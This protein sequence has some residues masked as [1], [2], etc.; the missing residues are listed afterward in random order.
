MTKNKIKVRPFDS[1]EYLD[2]EEAIAEYLA[3]SIEFGDPD[4]FLAALA[5]AARARGINRLAQDAGVGR[6][7]L[8]KTLSSGAK[9]RFE[10]IVKLTR[11][12]GCS[13]S[14]VPLAS[15]G[16]QSEEQSFSGD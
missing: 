14:I 10:T 7:S 5:Q 12:L 3:A 6:E 1:V 8:Y 15:N 16:Q 4:F 2:T 13:L 11:A 9:P